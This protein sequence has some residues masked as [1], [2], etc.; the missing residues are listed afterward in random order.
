[1]KST[2]DKVTIDRM[3]NST[4][5]NSGNTIAGYRIFGMEIRF[6]TLC[7]RDGRFNDHCPPF[8]QKEAQRAKGS[9]EH[10]RRA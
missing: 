7:V 8:L 10:S 2:R 4:Q 3:K 9:C 6:I 5:E 1:M